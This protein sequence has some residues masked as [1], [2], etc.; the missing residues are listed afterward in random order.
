MDPN[1]ASQTFYLTAMLGKDLELCLP[2]FRLFSQESSRTCMY[3]LQCGL[4]NS[5]WKKPP[6]VY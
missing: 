2:P 4:V 1:L 5:A 3:S 6:V